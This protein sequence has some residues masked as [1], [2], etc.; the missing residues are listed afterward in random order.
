MK[1]ECN[2]Y[3]LAI[4]GGNKE[5][6]RYLVW[7]WG[8]I[9]R[10]VAPFDQYQDTFHEARYNLALCRKNLAQCQQGTKRD[11]TLKMAELD[12]TRVHALY[13]TMGGEEW[14]RKYDS[15]LKTIQELRGETRP[16]GLPKPQSD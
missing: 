7:G 3:D 2:K 5:G 4:R 13:P 15:L 11:E 1:G 14:Y 16:P 9:A 10:R 8:G 12:I 6:K